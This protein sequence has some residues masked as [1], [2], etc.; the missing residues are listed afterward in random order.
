MG[1]LFPSYK[2]LLEFLEFILTIIN[3]QSSL[4]LSQHHPSQTFELVISLTIM[5]RSSTSQLFIKIRPASPRITSATRGFHRRS[6]HIYKSPLRPRPSSEVPQCT[7]I[8][9]RRLGQKSTPPFS[10]D[11]INEPLNLSD[12]AILL[13]IITLVAGTAGFLKGRYWGKSQDAEES[14]NAELESVQTNVRE[15]EE[16]DDISIQKALGWIF[17]PE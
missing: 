7:N 1:H 14:E 10:N 16:K 9:V 12:L 8:Q 11:K 4:T 3:H 2:V 15:G 17:P 13:V 5:L 6:P